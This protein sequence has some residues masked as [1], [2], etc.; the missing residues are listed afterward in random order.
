MSMVAG[1][2][3][4]G[5]ASNRSGRA[6]A[7][8]GREMCAKGAAATVSKVFDALTVEVAGAGSGGKPI[9]QQSCEERVPICPQ[10]PCII[11]QQKRSCAVI[12]VPVAAVPAIGAETQIANSNSTPNWRRNL[13]VAP[14]IP[15]RVSHDRDHGHNRSTSSPAA[16][17][18]GPH[19]FKK[20]HITCG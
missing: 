3:S 12:G 20:R 6:P 1:G 14:R 4:G 15:R 10:C 2:G 9:R 5:E 17:M 7:V 19:L 8:F 18:T 11:W 16:M 13:T